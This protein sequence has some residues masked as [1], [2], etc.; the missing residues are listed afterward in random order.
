MFFWIAAVALLLRNDADVIVI[1]TNERPYCTSANPSPQIL[2]SLI[3]IP[4]QAGQG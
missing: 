1:T 3:V 2:P 4:A